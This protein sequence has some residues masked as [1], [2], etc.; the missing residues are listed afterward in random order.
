MD[1]VFVVIEFAISDAALY[2]NDPP[3]DDHE[4]EVHVRGI[5]STLNEAIALVAIH[6]LSCIVWCD[7]Y[8]Q[9]EEVAF[10]AAIRPTGELETL[11]AIPGAIAM[12]DINGEFIRSPTI[13]NGVDMLA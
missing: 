8:W 13:H 6:K 4:L 1:T 7:D 10:N 11:Y 2:R 5:S 12:Y 9:I 3:G